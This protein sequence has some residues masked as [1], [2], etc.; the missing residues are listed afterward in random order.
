MQINCCFYIKIGSLCP[1]IFEYIKKNST[2]AVKM[3][4]NESEKVVGYIVD[5]RSNGSLRL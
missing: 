1:K 4:M 2:F 5:Y 3:E